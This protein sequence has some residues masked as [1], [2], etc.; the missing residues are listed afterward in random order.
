VNFEAGFAKAGVEVSFNDGP[1]LRFGVCAFGS[2]A[3]LSGGSF[4]A[5]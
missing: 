1:F 5:L 2:P 4:A 3:G